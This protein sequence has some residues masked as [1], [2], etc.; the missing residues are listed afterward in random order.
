MYFE[1]YDIAV[2]PLIMFLMTLAT[3]L[4]L[5]RKL[6]PLLAVILGLSGGIIYFGEGDIKKG[7]LIGILMASS[8]VGV[9]SGQKNVR[10]QFEIYRKARKNKKKK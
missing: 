3:E 8:A 6:S 7:V 2:V 9:Y 10:E 1:V 5:P 4:G